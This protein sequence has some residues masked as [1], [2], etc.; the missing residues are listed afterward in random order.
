MADQKR[1]LNIPI[2]DSGVAPEG[3]DHLS[4]D[5]IDAEV[6]ENGPRLRERVKVGASRGAA[7]TAAGIRNARVNGVKDAFIKQP[8]DA[9][10]EAA[11]VDSPQLRARQEGR[12]R[13]EEQSRVRAAQTADA[14]QSRAD[15]EALNKAAKVDPLTKLKLDTVQAGESYMESLRKSGILGAGE[16][17]ATQRKQLSGMHQVYASM[18]VLQCVQPLQQGLSG[19]SIASVLGMGASMWML[20]PNFRTQVGSFAGQM[21]DVIRAKIEDRGT[22]KD[23][24]AQGKFDALASQGKADQLAGRWQK[25][26]G[27]IEHAERGHR[28]PFTAQSAAMTEV[29]LAEAAYADMRRPGADRG[30]VQDRYESALSA[31]YEYVDDDG[32]NREDVSRSMRVIVG[33][34]LEKDPSIANVFTELGHG[35]F[36]KSEPREVYI[37]GTTDRAT[38]WTGDFVDSYEGRIISKGSFRLRPPMGVNEHRVL[39]AETL[40]AEMVSAKS[41]GELNDVLSQYVVATSVGQY[42]DVIGQIDDPDARG[43]LGKA[44][45]MFNSMAADGLSPAEQHFAYSAAYVD[46]VEVVQRLNPELGNK[47]SA[48]YGDQWRDKVAESMRAYSDLGAQAERTKRGKPESTTNASEPATGRRFTATADGRVHDGPNTRDGAH[49]TEDIVDADEVADSNFADHSEFVDY[50][51]HEG[52]LMDDNVSPYD[53]DIIDAEVIEDVPALE[54]GQARD[55]IVDGMRSTS[56]KADYDKSVESKSTSARVRQARVNQH[57]NEVETG[58]VTGFGSDD[59]TPLQDVDFELG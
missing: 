32:L 31:L 3:A 41:V 21:G 10:R 40:S 25:R 54:A 7:A 56:E 33:Q 36:T 30:L 46:A 22:K 20:S 5:V 42:P 52:F 27:K 38:V 14:K 12:A 49:S 2:Y 55:S 8:A 6:I 37:N 44:Q 9:V 35:R 24:K 45:T 47:W 1:N 26:L 53:E 13:R 57:Y 28:L 43:R 11:G 15:R 50:T 17:R 34:R 58:G 59:A 4:G 16:T 39:A 23:H 51:V 48:E 18:M 29:A 19:K